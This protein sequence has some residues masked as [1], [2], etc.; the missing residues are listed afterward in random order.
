M[1]WIGSTAL[2]GQCRDARGFEDGELWYRRVSA[3]VHATPYGL[4]DYFKMTDIPES[5]LKE[6]HPSLSIDEVRRAAIL[7][8]QAYLGAIEFNCRY[9][10][11]DHESVAQYR[12]RLILEMTSLAF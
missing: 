2:A 11:W 7:A 12:Q 3:V 9:M 1:T 6:L 4:L 8:T 5:E 10:G